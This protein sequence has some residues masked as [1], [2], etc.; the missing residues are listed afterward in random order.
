MDEFT[1]S[2]LLKFRLPFSEYIGFTAM[3]RFLRDANWQTSHWQFCANL[4]FNTSVTGATIQ[5]QHLYVDKFLNIDNSLECAKNDIQTYLGKY[6]SNR[7]PETLR[8]ELRIPPGHIILLPGL[9]IVQRHVY[10][11]YQN[12]LTPKA[13][14]HLPNLKLM[15]KRR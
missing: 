7:R 9:W 3:C 2:L 11:L 6:T 14:R 1:F 8:S 10:W 12:K 13:T 5:Q 4:W 15:S